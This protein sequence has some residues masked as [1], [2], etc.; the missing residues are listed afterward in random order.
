MESNLKE[1]HF[2]KLVNL[3]TYYKNSFKPKYIVWPESA[4]EFNSKIIQQKNI[5]LFDWLEQ[6]QL[7][8]TGLQEKII[9]LKVKSEIY[10]SAFII[11]NKAEVINYYDKV[12]LVPFG[13][14]IP[15]RNILSFKKFTIGSIDFSPGLNSNIIEIEKN[16]IKIGMLICYEIIFSRKKL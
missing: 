14:F 7:L 12:K 15:L 16:S 11:N 2:K 4:F 1:K 3:S 9:M 10:N 13:E 5:H 6:D 8:I